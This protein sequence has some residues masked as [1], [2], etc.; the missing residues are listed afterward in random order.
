MAV[1][2]ADRVKETS[3]TT[4][5]GPLTLAGAFNIN[6][7]SASAAG[8]A[9]GDTAPYS[10]EDTTNGGFE[11]GVGTWATGGIFTR[12]T[13]ES[14]SNA[15]AAVNWP[16][17]TRAI[18]IGLTALCFKRAAGALLR[19]V[20]FTASGTWTAGDGYVFGIVKGVGGGGG[21]GGNPAS[22]GASSAGGGGGGYFEKLTNTTTQT[23]TIG[24]GGTAGAANGA[25]GTGGTTSFGAVCSAT[26]GLGS[27]A[28]AIAGRVGGAGGTATGADVAIPGG[29]G[30]YSFTNG[31]VLS[32]FAAGGSTPFGFGSTPNLSLTAPTSP[33]ANTGAG[34]AGAIGASVVGGAG[35]TGVLYVYEYGYA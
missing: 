22:A 34:C 3:T 23:I 6:H 1:F 7:R 35:A 8:I 33:P 10:I 14:S 9:N 27:A 18:S 28:G 25:G 15:G 4:G 13:V 17:G 2:L 5:V 16:A 32:A 24:A 19:I 11:T 26:G 21:S 29:Q 31:G 20:K 12:T 30:G